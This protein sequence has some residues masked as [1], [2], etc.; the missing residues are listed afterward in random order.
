MN[1]KTALFA[2]AALAILPATAAAQTAGASDRGAAASQLSEVIVTATR[3]EES[4][5]SVPISVT[6][7]TGADLKESDVHDI[8]GLQFMA[9]SLHFGATTGDPTSLLASMRGMYV[10]DSTSTVDP[11]VG[12]YLNG[13]Y[14]AR[15]TG[16]NMALVDIQR[17]EVLRGPQGTLFGR[18]TMGGAINIVPAEPTHD[19]SGSLGA[20][21]GNYEARRVTGVVNV[22]IGEHLA[23]RVAAEHSENAAWGRNT[24]LNKPLNDKNLNFVRVSLKGDVGPLTGLIVYDYMKFKS[25]G[26]LS[27]T[28]YANPCGG[29]NSTGPCTLPTFV[30]RPEDAGLA[31]YINS[32][33]YTNQ[34]DHWGPFIAKVQGVSGTLTLDLGGVAT[35]K[36]ISA[37]RTT[38]RR[39]Y[40]GYDID[41]T[42]Y[43]IIQTTGSGVR[44][45]Q[46][47]H[48]FQVYGKA[49][50]NK[51]DWIGG[52]FYFN[53]KARDGLASGAQLNLFPLSRTQSVQD[54]QALNKSVGAFAQV[55]YAVMDEL[56]VT[57]GIR[58]TKDKRQLITRNRAGFPPTEVCSVAAAVLDVPGICRATLPMKSF[59]YKP[60]TL[61]LDWTPV[62]DTLVYG[63]VSRGFR[64]GGYNLRGTSAVTLDTFGPESAISYEVGV[65]TSLLDRRLRVNAAV[66]NVEFDD[67]Q[68]GR[69]VLSGIGAATATRTE[70]AA[71]ARIR[72]GELEVQAVVTDDLKLSVSGSHTDGKYTAALPGAV[73]ALTDKFLGIPKYTLNIAGD[74]RL[75]TP[76]AATDFHLEYDW[77]SR[78]YY[79]QLLVGSTPAFGIVNGSIAFHPTM[80]DKL[81]VQVY[82]RNLL[83]KK[84][85]DRVLDLT[86]SAIGTVFGVPAAPR[87]YGV[88]VDY[89]F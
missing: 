35:A 44:Q 5:Q 38:L 79:S 63:K 62:T 70:N 36:S 32:P 22:P 43:A 49:L 53:E 4:L 78:I 1:T 85:Y 83:G 65:K 39:S 51:L 61:G 87:M 76:I 24:L 89:E 75:D 46:T 73:I 29:P 17:V 15:S 26:Q 45:Y 57:A 13:V 21:V 77:R 28:V 81:T 42:P 68:V 10:T 30:G 50:D 20:A 34:G 67:I 66:Y 58:Y 47:S 84:Y 82:G 18:N 64:A 14:I 69:Q 80:N 54:G 7:V 59:K 19:L 55:S 60:W 72:G 37:Y 40:T 25:G 2:C 8:K 31:R 3:R 48:E 41:G 86:T 12:V 9:P 27:K 88:S 33:F 16:L 71:K 56:K 52:L 74:Y 23:A 6:A 11:A